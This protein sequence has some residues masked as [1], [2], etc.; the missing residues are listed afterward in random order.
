MHTPHAHTSVRFPMEIFRNVHNFTIDDNDNHWIALRLLWKFFVCTPLCFHPFVI[1]R[2]LF[3]CFDIE[4]AR[5]C[6]LYQTQFIVL[7]RER[8]KLARIARVDKILSNI[9]WFS[10]WNEM[11]WNEYLSK[12]IKCITVLWSAFSTVGKRHFLQKMQNKNCSVK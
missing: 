9:Q 3:N 6:S 5:H 7:L 10:K 4:I 2:S 1:L 12:Q 8:E 11:K